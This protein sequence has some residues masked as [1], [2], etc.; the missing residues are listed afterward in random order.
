MVTVYNILEKKIALMKLN[1]M[2]VDI[3]QQKTL[4]EKCSCRNEVHSPGRIQRVSDSFLCFQINTN[5]SHGPNLKI[6]IRGCRVG[7]VAER[8][9]C[10]TVK[11]Q[12]QIPVT[13]MKG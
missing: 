5:K 3:C 2:Y 6:K 1:I 11:N 10:V 12:V 4:K 8:S 9:C 13:Y 7:S